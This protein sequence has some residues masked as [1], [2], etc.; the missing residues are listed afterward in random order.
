MKTPATDYLSPSL[1]IRQTSNV[2]TLQKRK[3]RERRDRRKIVAISQRTIGNDLS[4]CDIH[5]KRVWSI[6]RHFHCQTSAVES[7]RRQFQPKVRRART[8]LCVC[9]CVCVFP[10]CGVIKSPS[11]QNTAC[12]EELLHSLPSRRGS[13]LPLCPRFACRKRA[14][15]PAR[16]PRTRE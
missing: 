12:R 3:K 2:K 10:L 8:K 13:V 15:L 1:V 7:K 5:R 4:R 6:D 11:T 14:R 16:G 9:V